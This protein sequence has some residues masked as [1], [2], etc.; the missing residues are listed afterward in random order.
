MEHGRAYWERHA[1]NYDR[2]L[3]V[4]GRPLPRMVALATETLRGC[5][6]VL[7]VAA[8]T[9]LLT[10][11]V[12]HV[13]Q[14][15]T[16]TDY[17]AAMIAL[18]DQRVLADGLTN[19]SC[20]RADVYDLKFPDASF[21]AVVCANLLHLVPDPVAAL[22]ALKRV[23]RPGGK[24]VAPTFCHGQTL[25][26]RLASRVIALTGFPASRRLTGQA[27]HDLME[28]AGVQVERQEIVPGL[29]PIAFVA[30]VFPSI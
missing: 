12:A 21:D 1:R 19:V 4:L 24:L 28:A 10:L 3:K 2:S 5:G 16:A 30:G 26:S 29:I 6:H 11:P 17:S 22:Q 18:L 23:V 7:E 25:T 15:L 27:L 9:G 13:V 20:V 14:R 8:G